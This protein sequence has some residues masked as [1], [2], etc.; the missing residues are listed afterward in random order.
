MHIPKCAGTTLRIALEERFGRDSLLLL[1]SRRDQ[2]GRP[3]QP[4]SKCSQ[5]FIIGH[6]G[7][8]HFRD[9]DHGRQV[10][11]F[12]RD[13]VERVLSHYYYWRNIQEQSMGPRLAKCLSLEDFLTSEIVAV[14]RQIVNLEAWMFIANIDMLSRHRLACVPQ[15]ELFDM[16]VENMQLFDFIGLTETFDKDLRFLNHRYCWGLPRQ[17]GRQNPS[18]ARLHYAELTADTR[19]LLRS[20]TRLDRRLYKYVQTRVYPRQFEG[21]PEHEFL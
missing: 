13:P 16:A 1:Y 6:F 9:D 5:P 4:F 21:Y 11:T 12:M 19:E 17:V 7:V 15:D 8:D 10:L 18:P 2:F 14:R 3:R 20:V